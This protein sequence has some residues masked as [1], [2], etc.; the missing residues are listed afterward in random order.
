MAEGR[1]TESVVAMK[2]SR[3]ISLTPSTTTNRAAKK[4]RVSHSTAMSAWTRQTE[5][6]R[7][8]KSKGSRGPGRNSDAQ[9]VSARPS[10]V[11]QFCPRPLCSVSSL[12][13]TPCVHTWS[14]RH[15]PRMH[16]ACAYKDT[17]V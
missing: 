14:A 11:R 7:A 2:R 12:P 3:P 9:C 13:P 4:R 17:H 16:S 15:C 6:E 8:E 5:N 10:A 1:F